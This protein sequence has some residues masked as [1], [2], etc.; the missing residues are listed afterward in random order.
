VTTIP[1]LSTQKTPPYCNIQPKLCA[2]IL[3]IFM[4]LPSPESNGCFF[5]PIFHFLVISAVGVSGKWKSASNS[6]Q[7]IAAL[8]FTGSLTLYSEIHGAVPAAGHEDFYSYVT[9]PFTI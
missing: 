9:Y 6:M 1:T 5:N 7:D 4:Q 8:L 2:L 3:A